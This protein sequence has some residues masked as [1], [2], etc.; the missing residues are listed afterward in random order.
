VR[1]DR[2]EIGRGHLAAVPFVGAG[3]LEVVLLALLVRLFGAAGSVLVGDRPDALPLDL[4]A[5]D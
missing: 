4:S 1:T 3:V 2:S 5:R